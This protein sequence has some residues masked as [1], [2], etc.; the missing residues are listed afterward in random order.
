MEEKSAEE[1]PR[2]YSEPTPVERAIE[3]LRECRER[4]Q[5]Q[6]KLIS[7]LRVKAEAYD[8]VCDIL[9][10]RG[11]NRYGMAGI[12]NETWFIDRALSELSALNEPEHG[13]TPNPDVDIFEPVEGTLV[14]EEELPERKTKES[15]TLLGRSVGSTIPA[16][17]F[18]TEPAVEIAPLGQRVGT[19][20]ATG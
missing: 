10:L 17:T 11:R 5:I 1:Y 4:I 16:P 3:A 19:V 7:E 14:S 2:T 12:V 20:T 13:P 18:T 15:A 8:V 9:N 6:E